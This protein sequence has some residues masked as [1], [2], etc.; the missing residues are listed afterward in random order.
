MPDMN[1]LIFLELLCSREHELLME[2]EWVGTVWEHPIWHHNHRTF[3]QLSGHIASFYNFDQ[4]LIENNVP[5]HHC[6]QCGNL[7]LQQP[8]NNTSL[9]D[10]DFKVLIEPL[11]TFPTATNHGHNLSLQPPE[12]EDPVQARIDVLPDLVP[13][14]HRHSLFQHANGQGG[15]KLCCNPSV[16]A[17]LEALPGALVHSVALGMPRSGPVQFG[18]HFLRTLN[19]FGVQFGGVWFRVFLLLNPRPNCEP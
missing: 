1:L 16:H 19:L 7:S 9:F 17:L 3:V 2:H 5:C 11:Q 14:A 15:A 6:H 12:A 13:R 8:P 4:K 18:G 10:E